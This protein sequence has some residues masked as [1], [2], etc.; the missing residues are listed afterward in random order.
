MSFDSPYGLTGAKGASSGIGTLSGIPYTAAVDEN[1][2][3]VT[4]VSTIAVSNDKLPPR[5]LEKYSSG[6]CVDSP[7][8]MYAAK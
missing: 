7:T 1:T 3:L 2:S 4:P 6:F 5:L 8:E